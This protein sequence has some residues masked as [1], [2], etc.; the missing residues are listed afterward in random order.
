MQTRPEPCDHD[1]SVQ[2]STNTQGGAHEAGDPEPPITDWILPPIPLLGAGLILS[3]WVAGLGLG[4]QAGG[5]EPAALDVRLRCPPFGGATYSVPEARVILHE[6]D[7]IGHRLG[8]LH[9]R[10]RRLESHCQ[11][12]FSSV[13]TIN[14]GEEGIET[15]DLPSHHHIGCARVCA[16][17][18][19]ALMPGSPALE[20]RGHETGIT[21]PK[22]YAP[23]EDDESGN[24][25]D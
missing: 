11:L 2:F 14:A 20:R 21:N 16:H 17:T 15:S 13:R 9:L 7:A 18:P 12:P 3:A 5:R 19:A 22:R 8:L 4:V 25:A 6:Q 1:A 24:R 23:A 10:L